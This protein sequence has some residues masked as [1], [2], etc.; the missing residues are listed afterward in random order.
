MKRAGGAAAVGVIVLA[1]TACTQDLGQA[2]DGSLRE[3]FSFDGWEEFSSDVLSKVVAVALWAGGIVVVGALI[4]RLLVL[5]S[6]FRDLVVTRRQSRAGKLA[7]FIALAVAALAIVLAPLVLLDSSPLLWLIEITALVLLTGAVLSLAYGMATTPHM[8]ARVY[9]RQGSE[10]LA[11]SVDVLD[12]MR[13]ANRDDPRGRVGTPSASDVNE[14]IAIADRTGTG[15]TSFVATVLQVFVNIAPWT[16]HVTFVEERA[17][18]ATLRRNGH[19]VDEV[20]IRCDECGGTDVHRSL[21][22]LTGAF[23]A[24]RVAGRYPDITGFYG[25]ANWQTVG[26]LAIAESEQA[27]DDRDRYLR[28]ARKA[29]PENINAEY[30]S[31]FERFAGT[32]TSGYSNLYLRQLRSLINRAAVLSDRP[33]PFTDADLLSTR[34]VG[35]P[36][37][38]EIPEP[39]GLFIRLLFEYAGAARNWWALE[40]AREGFDRE[41]AE[42]RRDRVRVTLAVL[43]RELMPEHP[44]GWDV[45]ADAVRRLRFGA[46]MA[47]ALFAATDPDQSEDTPEVHR[48]VGEWLREAEASSD[49]ETSYAY[50]GYLAQR[51]YDAPDDEER[52]RML[53]DIARRIRSASL[54]DEYAQRALADPELRLVGTRR[55]IRSVTVHTPRRAWDLRRFAD[56][57][58]AL[59]A[60]GI[61]DPA[62]LVRVQRLDRLNGSIG[63]TEAEWASMLDAAVL[64]ARTRD[65]ARD[66]NLS[67]EQVLCAARQLVDAEEMTTIAL[68]ALSEDDLPE[69]VDRVAGAV[70]WVPEAEERQR[71]D[72]LLTTLAREAA[73]APVGWRSR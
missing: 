22:A 8:S 11:W 12:Q 68:S 9:D 23:A 30:A 65:L 42:Q 29:D 10:N 73:E 18:I 60:E 27:G 62:D 24:F 1:L 38:A 15:L 43:V 21:L 41:Q 53:A 6:P 57:Q 32:S 50:A 72:E 52:K 26:Y 58:R 44:E 39:P 54:V 31:L 61:R 49:V 47:Y 40:R 67:E 63:I 45:A 36:S 25:A 20:E 37:G 14:V 3:G 46:A 71:V 56:W 28:L 13:R 35:T 7:G 64:L 16:L 5:G 51:A 19:V 17:V 70:Y 33:Q 59:Q 55:E 34:R 4:A 69:L 48:A 2:L 66:F